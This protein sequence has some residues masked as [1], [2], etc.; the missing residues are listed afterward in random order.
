MEDLEG[1]TLCHHRLSGETHIL[2][3]EGAAILSLMS[4][5]PEPVADL[6]ERLANQ[7]EIVD[8]DSGDVAGAVAARLD[9]FRALG[10]VERLRDT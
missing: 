6:A 10:L 5:A 2:S 7:F 4:D 9:E 3:D 8:L 1:L